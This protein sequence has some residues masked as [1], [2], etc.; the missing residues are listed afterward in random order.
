MNH[1]ALE[2]RLLK[3]EQRYQAP[4]IAKR[5]LPEWLDQSPAPG[6]GW[7]YDA[8]P[9]QKI[10][11]GDLTTRFKGYSGPIGSGKS[12]ALAYEALFL[13]R[14]NPGLVGLIGAPTYTML[15][16]ATQRTLF[17]VLATEGIA[18]TFNKQ[19]NR[20]RFSS[21]GSEIIFRSMDNPERLRG[22]NLAWFAL[23][24]LTYTH[25]EAW[26]RMLGRLRHPEAKRLCGCAVWT[27]KGYDWVY[28]LFVEQK[29]PDYRL[30][31][32][33]P[34][35]NTHLPADFYD[36]LK[37]SYN[38]L[39][40]RQEVLGEYLDIFGGNAYFAFSDA[41]IKET[42]YDPNLPICWALDF[43]RIPLCSVIC[44]IVD[45]NADRRH[46]Y[47]PPYINVL[48]EIALPKGH[49]ADACDAFI[50][51]VEKLY[52]DPI[53]IYIH[54]YGDKSGNDQHTNAP[55]TDYQMVMAKLR[56]RSNYEVSMRQNTG[57]PPVRDRVNETNNMLKSAS[58]VHRLFIDPKCESLIRDLKQV[59]WDQD[60]WGNVLSELSKRDARLTHSTDALGYL[61]WKEFRYRPPCGLQP[62]SIL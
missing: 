13:S 33:S 14:Q 41:N 21:N 6:T 8:L 45:P 46:P 54:I 61:V 4:K 62:G 47:D 31:Q 24:E 37:G 9:A 50:K 20:L 44:Q 22:P 40:F 39:F 56:Q 58:G 23:D 27:P 2:A 43:N 38:D 52:E 18:Y 42:K 3:V 10:F 19:D 51:R 26:T 12:H 55:I 60:Q 28:Q 36:Q 35:E 1:R 29:S 48:D 34:R 32:A 30:I 25:E 59:A 11:H 15:G 17:E 16:D 5:K 49:T 57:N 7:K 53:K